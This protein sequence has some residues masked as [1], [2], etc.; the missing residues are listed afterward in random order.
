MSS[1]QSHRTRLSS[2]FVAYYAITY[3]VMIGMMGFIVDRTARSAL[4][5]D[6]DENLA[7]A[8]RL[9]TQSLPED[10][11]DYQEWA[12]DV[13]TAG[14][15]RVTL[16]DT[17]GRVLADSHSDPSVMENHL[18]RPEVQTALSGDVGEAQRTSDSTGFE[19]RYSANVWLGR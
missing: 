3:L 9:A 18:Q 7:V 14:G 17:G 19:Q 12:Q 10:A 16:I 2:R 8:G 15:F 6:V 11:A 4:L 1:R 13:F 5:R